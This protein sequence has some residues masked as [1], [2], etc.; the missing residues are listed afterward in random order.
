[1]TMLAV[2]PAL[3][4]VDEREQTLASLIGEAWEELRAGAS[5][6]CPVCHGE[7]KPAYGR[8]GIPVSG[9]CRGCG[10]ELS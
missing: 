5:A 1:M 7:M 9:R 4:Q 10:S 2:A 3:F 6:E 8:H